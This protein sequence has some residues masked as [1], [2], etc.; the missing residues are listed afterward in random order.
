MKTRLISFVSKPMDKSKVNFIGVNSVAHILRFVIFLCVL[1]FGILFQV[2]NI[3]PAELLLV[4]NCRKGEVVM[5]ML[6]TEKDGDSGINYE[7][8]EDTGGK[9]SCKTKGDD[10]KESR[11]EGSDEE[12]GLFKKIEGNLIVLF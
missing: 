1:C 2:T 5:A 4:E 10:L 9:N 7:L 3:F 12:G 11:V 6:D 8:V